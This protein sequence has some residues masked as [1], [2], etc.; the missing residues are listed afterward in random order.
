MI[1]KRNLD[2]VDSANIGGKVLRISPLFPR[3]SVMVN[4]G[5]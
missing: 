5:R 1:G 3:L 2:D 4:A